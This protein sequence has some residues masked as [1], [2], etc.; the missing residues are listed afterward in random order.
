MLIV[1]IPLIIQAEVRWVDCSQLLRDRPTS[2]FFQV[3]GNWHV[4]HKDALTIEVIGERI[5]ERLSLIT[6]IGV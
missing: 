6:R 1:H 5:A 2:A 4:E 3:L